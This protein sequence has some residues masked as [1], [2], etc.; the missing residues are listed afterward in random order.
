MLFLLDAQEE[1]FRRVR[2]TNASIQTKVVSV[3]GALELLVEAG[4]KPQ[5]IDGEQFLVLPDDH[6]ELDLLQEALERTQ[7]A[8]VQLR[9]DVLT[10]SS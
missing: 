10:P 8:L 4:F 9:H 7:V 5:E 2:L 6:F 3:K 1:K